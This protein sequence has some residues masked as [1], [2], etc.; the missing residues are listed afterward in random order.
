MLHTSEVLKH[1]L[2]CKI[3]CSYCEST[4]MNEDGNVH[5]HEIYRCAQNKKEL[6]TCK[7]CSHSMTKSA[8]VE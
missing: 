3:A 6:V 2:H 4:C 5:L 7:Y 1:M 8:Y